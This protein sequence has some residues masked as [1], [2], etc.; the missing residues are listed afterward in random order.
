MHPAR[1]H[2]GH[3]AAQPSRRPSSTCMPNLLHSTT[4]TH[5]PMLTQLANSTR[6]CRG[7]R[8]KFMKLAAGH[9]ARPPSTALGYLLLGLGGGG[10]ERRGGGGAERRGVGGGEQN[11]GQHTGRKGA[12]C[13][14]AQLHCLDDGKCRRPSW[15]TAPPASV[16]TPTAR[17]VRRPSTCQHRH[18]LGT[19]RLWNVCRA[20]LQHT[21]DDEKDG[22]AQRR[23]DEL[24][25][26]HGGQ[27]RQGWGW[28]LQAVEGGTG[29]LQVQ[30]CRG[31]CS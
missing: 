20:A 15:A 10:A 27:G 1:E 5:Q 18:A 21:D 16:D 22:Q 28:C 23:H 11:R 7:T 19:Q 31:V 8:V 29:R 9:S 24:Q 17:L 12:G 13:S 30:V 4:L 3:T 6:Y 25:R 14:T 2:A 26:P